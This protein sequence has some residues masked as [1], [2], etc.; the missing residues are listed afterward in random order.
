MSGRVK[1][2]QHIA[3]RYIFPVLL[4]LYPFVGLL[5][6]F[7]VRDGGYSLSYFQYGTQMDPMWYL[8]TFL[9]NV[10]GHV[11]TKLPFGGTW[12]G[13]NVYTTLPVCAMALMAYYL[14]R[15][16][17]LPGWMIFLGEWI[18]ISLC[19]CPRVILYNYLTYLLFTAG[20]LSLLR[21]LVSEKH[22]MP[23][24]FLA[25]VCLGCN[26]HVRFPNIMEC[27]MIVTV[28]GY[29]VWTRRGAAG[30]LK[31]CV[32]CVAGY[33][34]GFLVPYTAIRLR[35]GN[36]AYPEM[37]SSLM[38]LTEEAEN[39]GI[40]GMVTSILGA[41][42]RTLSHM[43][44]LLPCIAA[45]VVMFVW[46]KERYL[47]AKRLLFVAGAV[48]LIVFYFK[49]GVFTFNYWYYDCM[50]QA[51]MM[52][53]IFALLL[54]A[55][56]IAGL[57]GGHAQERLLS[58]AAVVIIAVTPL[59]SDNYTY[60][61]LNHLFLVAPAAIGTFRR[62]Q[63]R[64]LKLTNREAH[65]TWGSMIAA[66][67]LVLLIQGTVFR[68][69]FVYGGEKDTRFDT[70]I[71]GVPK[72]AGMYT[73]GEEAERLER[74]QAYLAQ[75]NLAGTKT[76]F[77][78]DIPGCAWLFDLPPAIFT[79]WPDLDSNATERFD[80]ALTELTEMPLILISEER[81]GALHAERKAVLLQNFLLQN[82]YDKIYDD[83]V[84]ELYEPRGAGGQEVT[85]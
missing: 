20:T 10:T 49:T 85:P 22:T 66:L 41:Y 60:P 11:L 59:G 72:A 19:W 67:A 8:S 53:V 27:L 15:R 78:G 28:I 1:Q 70:R 38:G 24:L 4:F 64:T 36:S 82:A 61:V 58:L 14:L 62:A 56:D 31:Q 43:A 16:F 55:L 37:I 44:V 71:T 34:A 23:L 26:V 42:G 77:F 80:E 7:S 51:A 74:L 21:G 2:F 69:V 40:A 81:I 63:R 12:L 13:M 57:F 50:F 3:E 84:L 52:F 75:E 48:V 46:K 32:L 79:T 30:I 9:A 29:G 65:F 83:A 17:E 33:A 25:G 39:H 68:A 5:R 35:Y 6:D 18:A 76:L 73:T 47:T 45:G 54:F